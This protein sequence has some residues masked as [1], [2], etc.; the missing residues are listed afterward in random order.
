MA[1]KR[2]IAGDEPAPASSR[3]RGLFSVLYLA[4]SIISLSVFANAQMNHEHGIAGDSRVPG[5]LICAAAA[6]V[7]AAALFLSR[8][9]ASQDRVSRTAFFV[10]LAGVIIFATGA[11]MIGSTPSGTP[12]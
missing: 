7:G 6:V 11:L 12:G 4:A 3:L 8:R 1:Q 5:V 9:P 10:T 2:N